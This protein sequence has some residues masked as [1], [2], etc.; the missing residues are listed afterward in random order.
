MSTH[1]RVCAR[2]MVLRPCIAARRVLGGEGGGSSDLEGDLE[3][4][5]SVLERRIVRL[6]GVRLHLPL[7]LGVNLDRVPGLE[8][9]PH[10][11]APDGALHAPVGPLVARHLGPHRPGL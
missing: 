2:N 5:R 1:T 11:P 8:A 4:C 10:R 9:A 6:Q 7:E 3:L